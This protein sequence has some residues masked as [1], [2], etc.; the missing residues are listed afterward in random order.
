MASQFDTET[1][2]KEVVN[3]SDSDDVQLQENGSHHLLRTEVHDNR[4]SNSEPL[5][6]LRRINDERK[7]SRSTSDQSKIESHYKFE[8]NPRPKLWHEVEDR[9]EG[10]DQ[11]GRKIDDGRSLISPQFGDVENV[12]KWQSLKQSCIDN[13]EQWKKFDQDITDTLRIADAYMDNKKRANRITADK[14][15]SLRSECENI[16]KENDRLL[17]IQSENVAIRRQVNNRLDNDLKSMI[18]DRNELDQRL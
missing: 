12:H 13:G 16:V 2:L 8:Y 17:G 15:K 9:M 18:T 11:Y 1:E 4:L 3:T 10:R 6:R 5:R 14:E 7:N